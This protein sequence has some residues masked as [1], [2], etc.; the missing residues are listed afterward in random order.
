[1]SKK[2]KEY[3]KCGCYSIEYNP[4]KKKWSVWNESNSDGFG[5]EDPEFECGTKE[6]ARSAMDSCIRRDRALEEEK[7]EK[8]SKCI[9]AIACE[10]AEDYIAERMGKDKKFA[11]LV[12]M[13]AST[14]L[15][16]QHACFTNDK[17]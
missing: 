1:M 6:A 9:M 15:R 11:K 7:M 8:F 2:S 12:F 5:M 16:A 10:D 13:A 3:S 14:L 17:F 4:H